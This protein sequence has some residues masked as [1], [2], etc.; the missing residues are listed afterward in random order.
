[1]TSD[2]P[3]RSELQSDDLSGAEAARA[4]DERSRGGAL[5]TLRRIWPWGLFAAAIALW[6]FWAGP[7]SGLP[8]GDQAPELR[9]PWTAG[10]APFDLGAERGHVTVLAFWATWCPACRAEGPALS[11]VAQHVEETG[12][13]VVGVSVDDGTLDD[14]ARAARSL[15][16]TYPIALADRADVD[17]F[18][19]ELLPTVIIVGPDGHI[20]R[21][22]AGAVGEQRLIEAVEEAR[23]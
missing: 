19:V 5:G 10:D 9:V 18:A 6:F 2:S 15:G 4:P 21:S 7:R 23:H 14:V 3:A 8:A 1:M 12:D 13:R 11:R 16:M 20:V 17:R 22:F